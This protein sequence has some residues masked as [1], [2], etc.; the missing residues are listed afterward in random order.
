[1]HF[2]KKSLLGLLLLL[3]AGLPVLET[4]KVLGLAIGWLALVFS[5][6]KPGWRRLC[7]SVC[8]TALLVGAK[9]LLP[10]ADISEGHN[11]FLAIKDGEALQQGLPAKVFASWKAQFDAIYPPDKEPYQARSIWRKQG[12]PKTLFTNSSDAIW[13]KAKYTRQVN[14]ID[15]RSFAEFRGGFAN[16]LQYNFWDGELSRSQ[17]PFFVMYELTKLSV[18]SKLAWKGQLF[19]EKADGNYEE[20]VHDQVAERE[21]TLS[22]VGKRVY[23][24]S[25]PELYPNL[26][27]KLNPS[28]LLKCSGW[29]EGILTIIGWIT[30]LL[31]M[32]RPRWGAFL[33]SLVFFGIGYLIIVYFISLNTHQYLGG[34]YMPHGG[35]D[36]GMVHDSLGRDMAM[37]AGKGEIVQALGG[38]EKVYWFTPGMRY[39]RMAEKMVFGDTYHGY[40][41]VLACIPIV[42]F[43]LMRHFI[44]FKWA[45]AMTIVFCFLPVG[46]F[47][48]MQYLLNA[49]LGYGEALGGGLYLLGLVL[50][51]MTQPRLGGTH[52]NLTLV[53]VAG[54]VLAVSMFVRPNFAF[55]VAWLGVV[56]IWLSL[57]RRD[58]AT[59]TTFTCGIGL[60]LW[61]PFHNWYYGG[62]FYL[63]SKAGATISVPFGIGDYLTAVGDVLNGNFEGKPTILAQQLVKWLFD[64]GNVITVKLRLLAIAVHGISLI[65]LV[66]T[67]WVVFR[68]IRER[69]VNNNDL[70]IVAIAA[71]FALIPM[72]FIFSA[73]YRY[74]MLGWELCM[75][76]F[77]V[78]VARLIDAFPFRDVR[79]KLGFS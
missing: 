12:V 31:L 47:S 42:I 9:I 16:E 70:A 23:A 61:M 33:R 29:A 27:Y 72:L 25:F 13:R 18:G 5:V 62:E 3:V 68:W 77:I 1:M 79:K 71:I 22:D 59:I 26:Y 39:F 52:R 2:L 69:F 7:M 58:F 67:F 66:L 30:I 65:G 15:F 45:Y 73:H 64:P 46:N 75:V 34:T 11:V 37:M 41:L 32:I 55:A 49:R 10:Q 14:S 78:F 40:P 54:A 74:A 50:M 51:L 21:I 53:W 6:C 44:G 76:I 24:I 48:Y 28:L 38:G 35:G 8:V 17:M 36:D 4:W 63:I 20:I 56:Y 57:M 60:A 19:W 43:Y